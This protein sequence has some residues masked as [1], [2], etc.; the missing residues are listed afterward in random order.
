MNEVPV[1]KIR[2]VLGVFVPCVCVLGVLEGGAERI[3]QGRGSIV[4]YDITSFLGA[5]L[6]GE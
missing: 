3:L 2:N 6:P 5:N 1:H 4:M